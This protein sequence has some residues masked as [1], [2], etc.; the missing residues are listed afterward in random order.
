MAGNAVVTVGEQRGGRARRGA[1]REDA[2]AHVAH[3]EKLRDALLHRLEQIEALAVEQ[4]RMSG[5]T[6][7]ERE[8]VLRERLSTLEASHARLQAESRRR[9][10]EWQEFLEQL[11]SDR[12]LLAEAWERLEQEQTSAAPAAAAQAPPT[13]RISPAG[14]PH[15]AVPQAEKEEQEGEDPVAKAILKQFQALQGDVR[16][17]AKGRG[18]G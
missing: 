4:A 9:E 12:R 3:L 7:S 17:N 2:A 1:P 15:P 18:G 5:A 8:A 13:S 16:R 10:Q 6:P 14:A 11:E